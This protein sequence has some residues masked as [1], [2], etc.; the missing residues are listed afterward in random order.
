MPFSLRDGGQFSTLAGSMNLDPS[1]ENQS[2]NQ[3]VVAEPG[4]EVK[5]QAFWEKNRTFI[6]G[7]CVVILV[8]IIAREGWQFMAASKE[9]GLQGEYA[10]VADRPEQLPAFAAANSGHTLGG[11]AYLRVADEKYAAGDYRQA[12]ENYTKAAAS[13]KVPAVVGRARVGAAISQLNAGDKAAAET[14]LKAIAAD[15]SLLKTARAEAMYHSATLAHEAGN[16][17]EV[18]RLV[19]EI[20]K[21]DGTGLWAERAASLQA[22]N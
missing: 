11:V 6:L 2:Q 8:A 14:A 3:T 4:F 20:D 5:A 17:A 18:G 1:A 22:G 13:L 15:A 10:K 21:L 7:V 16:T 12:L 19:G 9:R